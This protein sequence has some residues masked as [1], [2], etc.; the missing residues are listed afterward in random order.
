MGDNRLTVIFWLTTHTQSTGQN[1]RT[2]EAE[3]TSNTVSE[4]LPVAQNQ[5]YRT[6]R[7]GWNNYSGCLFFQVRLAAPTD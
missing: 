1:S 4:N 5:T 3:G 6:L 7:L 2:G